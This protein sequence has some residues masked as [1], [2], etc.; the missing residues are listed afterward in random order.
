MISDSIQI[1]ASGFYGD[2]SSLNHT[3]LGK[4]YRDLWSTK[5]TMPVF[6][7]PDSSY[8]RCIK[9]GGGDQT[10]KINIADNEGKVYALR[11]IDKDQS[12]AIHPLLQLT[13]LRPLVR[14]ETAAMNPYGALI[15][16]NLA[17]AAGILHTNPKLVFIPYMENLRR[18]CSLL[19][20]GRV[21]ILEEELDEPGWTG[22]P[23]FINAELLLKTD[24]MLEDLIR[25]PERTID[26]LGF[27]KA[28]LFDILIGDWDRHDGQWVW[29][30]KD[31]VYHPIPVDRDMV[32]Y[33]FDDGIL[34]RWFLNVNNK[35]Q[36][37][38]EDYKDIT[39]YTKN[40]AEVD[41]LFLRNVGENQFVEMAGQLQ[42]SLTEE[43]IYQAFLDYPDEIFKMVGNR[44]AEILKVRKDKL[45]IAAKEFFAAIHKVN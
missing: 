38:H 45:K 5:V 11:S 42:V 40:S 7:S 44:H 26:T 3:L 4:K 34:N 9:P 32:F 15:A 36:S 13:F 24:D 30:L 18:D 22:H 1:E 2:R 20:A 28:R 31:K 19:M 37:Y 25:K 16:D 27:L 14:D 29:A 39:G 12:K 41:T 33:L 10:I 23:D 8:Y 35:F 43:E 21:A 6:K 17:E